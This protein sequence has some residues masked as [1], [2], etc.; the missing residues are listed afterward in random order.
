MEDARGDSLEVVERGTAPPRTRKIYSLDGLSPSVDYRVHNSDIVNL[1]RAI[2]ERVF[3]VSDGAGGF[4]RPPRPHVATFNERLTTFKSTLARYLP[5]TIPITRHEFVAM[6]KDRRKVVYQEAADSL[7]TAPIERSD[8]FLSSFVKAEKI[9]FSAK[10]DPAPRVIQPRRPRYNVEVGCYLKPIEHRVYKAIAKTFGE[11][12][13]MKGYNAED[14]GRVVEK[15]W[16]SFAHPA[17]IGLDASRF[18]QHCSST[19]LS[20]EHSIY[21][22]IYGNGRTDRFLAKLLKWQIKNRGYGRCQDGFLKYSVEGCRMS[23]D[24]NTA[25]G[26]CLIMC[27]LVWTYAHEKQIKIKLINNGDDCVV[28]CESKDVARF[29]DGLDLWFTEMGYSMKVEA[30]VYELERVVFCQTQP[31]WTPSGY[32]MVRDPHV[33]VT[34]DCYSINPLDSEFGM[35]KY[36]EVLGKGGLSLTGGI[37]IWQDFY[38]L[39][40]RLPTREQSRHHRLNKLLLESGMMMLASGMGRSYTLCH[41]QT[42]FSFWRAFG[43]LPDEQLALEEYYSSSTIQWQAETRRDQAFVDFWPSPAY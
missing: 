23:G 11:P 35:K 10:P 31:V 16:E 43:I 26:N 20:W 25:M 18:D 12:T 9:N 24:M 7:E 8:S 34:K 15:K 19:A 14:L 6:Y 29:N 2:K 3:S 36:L 32:I 39:L 13:V 37:P 5:S 42:R 30:P 1:E 22:L 40:Q 28:F 33:A 41:P 27:A 21:Q 38:S 4:K 17:A